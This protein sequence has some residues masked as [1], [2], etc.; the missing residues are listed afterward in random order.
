ME[1]LYKGKYLIAVYSRNDEME[2]CEGV[3]ESIEQLARYTDVKYIKCVISRSLQTY[4]TFPTIEYGMYKFC[5]ID[6]YEK[7]DDI[8]QEEDKLFIE[9][10]EQNRKES[11]ADFC[12]RKKIPLRS[13]QRH[14]S[15]YKSNLECKYQ[16]E[17]KEF[18]EKQKQS[19]EEEKEWTI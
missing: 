18:Q 9:F 12:D 14:L 16:K 17:I 3:Y 6:I 8:F 1:R 15:R 13:F 4:H 19:M 11:I 2:Y 10:Y 5:F 7:H